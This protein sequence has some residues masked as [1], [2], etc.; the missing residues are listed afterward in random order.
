MLGKWRFA[1]WSL[2]LIAVVVALLAGLYGLS[3]SVV[4]ASREYVYM[5]VA[6]LPENT[7]GLVLGTSNFTQSGTAN[8]LFDAR[9][10][11]GAL[12]Y[13]AG[14]I[15]HLLLS[16]ANPG[17]SYNEPKR[18][19]EAL[20]K[21][22]IPRSAMTLDYAGVR[23]L[24][25]V[26]RAREIFGLSR[27]T[28]ISQRFHDYRAV[29]LARARGIEA[30]AFAAPENDRSLPFRTNA[31]EF[32]ARIMALVDVHVLQTRPRYLGKPEPIVLSGKPTVRKPTIQPRLGD[33]DDPA[34]V[35]AFVEDGNGKK[36]K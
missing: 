13:Q 20:L 8:P 17:K 5:T 19:L 1:R 7:V 22:D 33:P 36:S 29:Y 18:M 24:D 31:R 9:V 4:S 3:R 15:Q 10:Q 11:A 35:P 25:S 26:V 14:K 28:I 30:V 21:Y 27:Y 12:L 6:D 32:F 23:T 16:G 34:P 2:A